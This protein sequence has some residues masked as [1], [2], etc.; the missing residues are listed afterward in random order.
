[1][2]LHS[3][4]TI[5]LVLN[6]VAFVGLTLDHFAQFRRSLPGKFRTAHIVYVGLCLCLA[7]INVLVLRG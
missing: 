6:I 3:I 5:A 4:H 7:V 1:M 2:H